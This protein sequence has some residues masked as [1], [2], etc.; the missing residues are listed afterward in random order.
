MGLVLAGRF[1]PRLPG[2]QERRRP[3]SSRAPATR[4][5]V[6]GSMC[7]PPRRGMLSSERLKPGTYGSFYNTVPVPDAP[8]SAPSTDAEKAILYSRGGAGAW[9]YTCEAAAGKLR[10][11]LRWLFCSYSP[12]LVGSEATLEVEL[13]GSNAAKWWSIEPDGKRGAIGA[14]RRLKQELSGGRSLPSARRTP[15][16]AAS[17]IRALAR[18]RQLVVAPLLISTSAKPITSQRADSWPG[19]YRRSRLLRTGL[20]R[21][22]PG[23]KSR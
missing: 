1:W 13:D 15:R 22:L 9:E 2:Q 12:E 19:T 18:Q 16:S 21:R 23:D 6:S 4:W 11:K 14:G 20:P 8:R 3:S 7:H 10:L 17:P 5:L